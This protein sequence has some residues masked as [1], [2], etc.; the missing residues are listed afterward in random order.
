MLIGASVV[1]AK[2]EATLY[3]SALTHSVEKGRVVMVSMEDTT[4]Y[5]IQTPL[6]HLLLWNS[7][8]KPMALVDAST[9]I[10]IIQYQTNRDMYT[11]AAD[12]FSNPPPPG[13]HHHRLEDLSSGLLSQPHYQV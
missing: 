9:S 13:H 6:H 10:N 4:F 12:M 7:T 1:F 5:S 2:Q 11:L 8:G 3:F